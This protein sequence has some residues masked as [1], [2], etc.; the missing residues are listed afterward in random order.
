MTALLTLRHNSQ[1]TSA[2]CHCTAYYWHCTTAYCNC[3]IA[4]TAPC[5]HCTTTPC[6][7]PWAGVGTSHKKQTRSICDIFGYRA[8]THTHTWHTHTHTHSKTDTNVAHTPIHMRHVS[9]PTT[10][11]KNMIALRVCVTRACSPVR[12]ALCVNMC[13]DLGVFYKLSFCMSNIWFWYRCYS[14]LCGIIYVKRS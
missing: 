12:V 1:C 6:W 10:L 2:Y 4:V 5:L 11:G 7:R 3:T 9:Q 13:L 8:H 14:F